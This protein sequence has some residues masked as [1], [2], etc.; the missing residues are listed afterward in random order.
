[1][2]TQPPEIERDG[3]RAGRAEPAPARRRRTRCCG[4]AEQAS[5][6]EPAA[7]AA[8]C[9]DAPCAKAADASRRR[10]DRRWPRRA[11]R[12]RRD[13]CGSSSA[14]ASAP[15]WPGGSSNPADVDDIVQWVFLQLHRSLGEIRSGERI[16]AWLYSTARRAIADYYRSRSRRREVP[17]GD[18]LDLDELGRERTGAPTTATARQEVASLPRARGGAARAGRPGRDRPDRDPG[19]RLADAAAPRR[20]S[21]SRDEVQGPAGAPPAA[22]GDARLLPSPSTPRHAD[23]CAWRCRP[24]PA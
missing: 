22:Q 7:K 11:G 12:R 3:V 24:P 13:A 14:S 1:M 19:L 18:A 21:R 15:S 2:T 16:H 5:C 23:R 17:S 10:R 9:G 6:C 20:T 8:C 4:P